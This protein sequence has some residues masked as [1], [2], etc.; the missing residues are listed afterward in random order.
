MCVL[1][2]IQINDSQKR[3]T[4]K[5]E[6]SHKTWLASPA[7]SKEKAEK[8][9]SADMVLLTLQNLKKSFHPAFFKVSV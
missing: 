1:S 7:R 5:R 8:M 9:S 3:E 6:L 4:A 2:Y